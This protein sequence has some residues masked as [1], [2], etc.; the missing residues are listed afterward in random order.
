M[1]KTITITFP[2]DMKDE[3]FLRWGAVIDALMYV[4]ETDNINISVKDDAK[5]DNQLTDEMNSV[6]KELQ[7]NE[8]KSEE[9]EEVAQTA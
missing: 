3:N 8:W 9:P 5:D 2:D 7:G 4:E 6:A 1:A